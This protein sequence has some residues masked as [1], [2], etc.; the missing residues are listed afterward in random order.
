MRKSFDA[1]IA[2]NKY[3]QYCIP[4]NLD[5]CPIR[6]ALV[7][8][9]IFEEATITYIEKLDLHG[10]VIHAGAY[11]GDFLPALSHFTGS[12]RHVWAFEPSTSFYTHAEVTC[13]INELKNVK[14]FNK[15]V[16]SS[17]ASKW[18]TTIS[19]SNK[20]LGGMSYI[21]ETSKNTK[22]ISCDV[23]RLDDTLPPDCKVGLIHLDL[24][25]YEEHALAGAINIIN[26]NKPLLILETLPTPEWIT[27]YLNPL[28]YKL[29][30]HVDANFIL[31]TQPD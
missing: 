4:A 11:F 19:E 21:S 14:L 24:E 8:G 5:E 1:I 13:Q 25:G 12:T 17:N 16:G 10:D 6:D 15:A 31:S 27:K 3:G 2:S 7:Q 20:Q 29:I 26:R 18:L 28:G 22:A 9:D 30:D 23:I